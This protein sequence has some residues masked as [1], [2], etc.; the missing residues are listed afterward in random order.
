[1][2]RHLQGKDGTTV[3]TDATVADV[4][5]LKTRL[6]ASDRAELKALGKKPE[7]VLPLAYEFSD[8]VYAVRETESG[9]PLAIFG[10]TP[11]A[12]TEGVGT[13]WMLCTPMIRKVSKSFLKQVPGI[14]REFHELYPEGLHNI[15]LFTQANRL[16]LK[17]IQSC[18]FSFGELVVSN[19]KPF[20]YFFKKAS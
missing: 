15:A 19:G 1:V 5:Y 17:W 4:H 18:G 12:G 10:V 9:K 13:V 16:N 3:I 14:L 7:T 2:G 11:T 20:I 6:R 8:V